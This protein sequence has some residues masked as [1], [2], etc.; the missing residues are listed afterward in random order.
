MGRQ[1]AREGEKMAVEKR[2]REEEEELQ[3]FS[4]FH[5]TEDLF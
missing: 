3:L 5:F 4:T 1:L 2:E